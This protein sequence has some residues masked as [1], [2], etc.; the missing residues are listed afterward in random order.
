MAEELE[1]VKT[2]VTHPA[3]GAGVVGLLGWL[4]NRVWRGMGHRI[5]NV[6]HAQKAAFDAAWKEIDRRRD[7]D[8]KL[9]DIV[10]EHEAKDEERFERVVNES[11][12]RHDELM[13]L[14]GDVR[15]DIA[16]M[17]K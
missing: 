11:R 16:G 17:K 1:T 8:E 7:I 3:T 10:R 6:E 5:A 9:F 2:I 13:A 14:M 4:A 12:D 15:A